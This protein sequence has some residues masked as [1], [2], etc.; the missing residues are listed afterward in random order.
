MLK[1]SRHRGKR[2]SDGKWVYGRYGCVLVGVSIDKEN[3]RCIYNYKHFIEGWEQD[4]AVPSKKSCIKHEVI[5]ETV[6]EFSGEI[7]KNGRK[8]YTGDIVTGIRD[9]FGMPSDNIRAEVYCRDGI[10]YESYTGSSLSS[11]R[12][13]KGTCLAVIGNKFDNQ[14]LLG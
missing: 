14:E 12:S 9:E 11:H 4:V 5:P 10:F 3:D 6:G 13:S 8:I 1:V 7:D 2:V